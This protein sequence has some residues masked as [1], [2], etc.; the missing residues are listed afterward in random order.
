MLT[1][2]IPIYQSPVLLETLHEELWLLHME[3]P[4]NNLVRWTG[5]NVSALDKE[6]GLVAIKPSGIRYEALRPEHMVIVDL[7]GAW[8]RASSSRRPTPPAICS[9]IVTGRM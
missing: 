3:L 9:S 8:L 7:D 2:L 6:S 5:G 4:K 1:I